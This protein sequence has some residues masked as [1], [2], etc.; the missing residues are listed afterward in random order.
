MCVRYAEKTCGTSALTA[1]KF[2]DD[3][4][5]HANPYH[6]H[7]NLRGEYPGGGYGGST[8]YNM[9]PWL[10][11]SLGHSKM[12][13]IALDARGIYGQWEGVNTLPTNLDP[14]GGHS[15]TVPTTVAS[16]GSASSPQNVTFTGGS[17]YHY[18]IVDGGPGT[19]NCFGYDGTLSLTSAQ[20]L[21]STYCSASPTSYC[22]SYGTI[23]YRLG[24]Q[25][26]N[27]QAS[28]SSPSSQYTYTSTTSCTAC[29]GSCSV[30]SSAMRL[31]ASITVFVASSV[32]VL[33]VLL[34]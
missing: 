31:G 6:Y 26:F 30:T 27:Q 12:I 28:S 25:I 10:N 18:H 17:F 7:I 2:M 19:V 5:A 21:Y 24:C 32:A 15:G 13:G 33:V 22:T 1:T 34:F 11:S 29:S 23:S 3:S 14:C 20:T 4:G 9:G 8:A 16:V